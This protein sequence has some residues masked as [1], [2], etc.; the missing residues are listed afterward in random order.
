MTVLL[1]GYREHSGLEV[2]NRRWSDGGFVNGSVLG[3]VE[4]VEGGDV[5]GMRKKEDDE[6][7]G[8]RLDLHRM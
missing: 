3:G 7:E 4:E 5:A 2:S 1:C 8:R 6:S